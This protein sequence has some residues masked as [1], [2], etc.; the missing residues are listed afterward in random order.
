M[1]C[2]CHKNI[3][4]VYYTCKVCHSDVCVTCCSELR[5]LQ[6][7]RAKAAASCSA[8]CLEHEG[9]SKASTEGVNTRASI[10]CPNP[11][12]DAVGP[13]SLQRA[14][15]DCHQSA[16]VAATRVAACMR[17]AAEASP[18]TLDDVQHWP[19]LLQ[20]EARPLTFMAEA[21]RGSASGCEVMAG[22][23]E[24]ADALQSG[25]PLPPAF[26]GADRNLL[27]DALNAT[28][29]ELP[30]VLEVC[31]KSEWLEMFSHTAASPRGCSTLPS[32]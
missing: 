17:D 23:L 10:Q 7:S 26:Q 16:L 2:R 31:C 24:V 19:G 3:A 9:C 28:L 11:K 13:L 18:I 21:P 29:D 8:L 4:N 20:T 14:L 5:D 25:S 1:C 15:P 30:K 27:Q 6:R 22:R 12:C 32:I